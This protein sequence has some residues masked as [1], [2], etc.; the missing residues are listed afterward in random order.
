M[1]KTIFTFLSFITLS[2]CQAQYTQIPDKNFEQWLINGAYKAPPI[3]GK[4]ETR[5]I[6]N[7]S[8]LNI[9][10]WNI[11]DLTGIQDFESLRNFSASG[12][13][14]DTLDLSSN[15]KLQ[16]FVCVDCG[17]TELDFSTNTFLETITCQNNGLK[18]LIIPPTMTQL[19]INCTNNSLTNIDV[20]S[21][22]YLERLVCDSNLLTELDVSTNIRSRIVS[23]ESNRLNRFKVH[24]KDS[25]QMTLPTISCRNNPE[26]LCIEVGDSVAFKYYSAISV[27]KDSI[28]K[29]QLECPEIETNI[30]AKEYEKEQD[31]II[32]P[33]PT[34]NLVTISANIEFIN[35]TLLNSIGE[36]LLKFNS[37]NG[38]YTFNMDEYLPGIYVVRLSSDKGEIRTKKLV[39]E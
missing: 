37:S 13:R 3:E 24:N 2:I 39:K 11:T 33:N 23:C 9:S 19:K 4:V 26:L 14:F 5:L 36:T 31:F 25:F 34:S 29:Y 7:V 12:S 6:K 27:R 35:L 17:I 38:R 22:P 1:L 15:L 16:S 8:T 30:S 20:S 18:K 21:A 28:A 32:Y 10:G